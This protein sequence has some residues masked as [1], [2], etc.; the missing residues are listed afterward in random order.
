MSEVIDI[1]R[2]ANGAILMSIV[3]G[4]RYQLNAG[5]GIPSVRPIS[6]DE[7]LITTEGMIAL[8]TRCGY[9]VTG[10]EVKNA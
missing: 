8:L 3:A 9:R 1:V 4:G 5:I 10:P 7:I 6:E 2:R